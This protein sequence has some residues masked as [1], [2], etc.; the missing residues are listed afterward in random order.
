[1]RRRAIER[2]P[3]LRFSEPIHE[4]L[5]AK[6]DHSTATETVHCHEQLRPAEFRR[7]LHDLFDGIRFFISKEIEEA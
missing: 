2:A 1:M 3:K 7:L 6:L 4:A 5:A